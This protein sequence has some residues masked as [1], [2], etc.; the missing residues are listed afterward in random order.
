LKEK[1]TNNNRLVLLKKEKYNNNK[2]RVL[3]IKEINRMIKLWVL[4]LLFKAMSIIQINLLVKR[5]QNI[6]PNSNNLIKSINRSKI[7]LINNNLINKKMT[8]KNTVLLKKKRNKMDL[9]SLIL[10]KWKNMKILRISLKI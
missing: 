6:I 10:F 7:N 5:E 1:G 8:K 3:E 9:N 2:S 4:R